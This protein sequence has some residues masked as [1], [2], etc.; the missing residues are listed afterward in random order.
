[1]VQN[2]LEASVYGGVIMEENW[3]QVA[4]PQQSAL[5]T[6]AFVSN[7]NPPQILGTSN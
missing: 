2:S 3:L 4:P 5:L 6:I 7:S 1:M